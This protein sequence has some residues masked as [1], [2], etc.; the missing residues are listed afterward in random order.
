MAYTVFG[1]LEIVLVGFVHFDL[2][3]L[4][5]VSLQD[6]SAGLR[7]SSGFAVF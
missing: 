1:G 2:V 7:G 5:D 6:L 3:G 4:E